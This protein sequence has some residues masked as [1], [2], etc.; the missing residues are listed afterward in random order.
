MGNKDTIQSSLPPAPCPL[1]SI[2]AHCPLP[3]I[4]VEQLTQ[5]YGQDLFARIDRRG[6]ALFTPGWFDERLMEWSMADEA[7]KV[8]LFRF[9]DAL[10]LLHS[11]QQITRHLSEYFEEAKAALP[12]WARRGAGWL[13]QRGLVAGLLA[14]AAR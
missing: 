14:K 9:I 10:P 2:S 8:Q 1:P 5:A 6:P 4:N 12:G 3:A 7:V 11:P 13:P